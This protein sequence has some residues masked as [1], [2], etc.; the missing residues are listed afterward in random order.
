MD[1]DGQKMDKRWTKVEDEEA[2]QTFRDVS[3]RSELVWLVSLRPRR[4]CG[5][6]D[7]GPEPQGPLGDLGDLGT[8]DLAKKPPIKKPANPEIKWFKKTKTHKNHF[9]SLRDSIQAK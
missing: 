1:K 9:E 3:C 7:L 5:G 2:G 6:L 4:R 8:S